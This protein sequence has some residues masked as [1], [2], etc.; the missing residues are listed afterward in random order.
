MADTNSSE[1]FIII[2]CFTQV[3]ADSDI[4]NKCEYNLYIYL[5]SDHQ[6]EWMINF[7]EIY[8]NVTKL[9]TVNR[10]Q[11]YA[12]LSFMCQSSDVHFTFCI[13]NGIYICLQTE[14]LKL[15]REILCIFKTKELNLQNNAISTLSP[16]FLESQI[17]SIQSVYLSKKH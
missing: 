3:I 15:N 16:D 14:S 1:L 6:N 13:I 7:D 8:K 12:S 9:V 2:F 11:A 4:K 5:I 17:S 10:T